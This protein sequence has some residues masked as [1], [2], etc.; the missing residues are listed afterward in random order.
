MMVYGTRGDG[1][2]VVDHGVRQCLFAERRE[3]S[4]R[5]DEAADTLQRLFGP[6]P[7]IELFARQRR[8]RWVSWGN[9]LAPDDV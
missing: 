6:V 8:A 5:P 2:K 4:R 1:L 3:H 7:R 9:E